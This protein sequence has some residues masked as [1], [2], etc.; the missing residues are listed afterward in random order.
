MA[1][2]S[3]LGVTAPKSMK[4]EEALRFL[5]KLANT[6]IDEQKKVPADPGG[7]LTTL[8]LLRRYLDVTG[9]GE[10]KAALDKA[11][12][13][14]DDLKKLITDV[15]KLLDAAVD[16]RLCDTEF[17]L[18]RP[19]KVRLAFDEGELVSQRD[20]D[21]RESIIDIAIED[22][23]DTKVKELRFGHC[24]RQGCGRLFYKVKLNQSYCDHQCANKAASARRAKGSDEST[25]R[26]ENAPRKHKGSKS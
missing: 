2:K 12:S 16:G 25:P 26:A 15:K 8:Y 18:T 17:T 9:E 4:I 22:L 5:V 20:G 19:R 3:E 24:Q 11:A 23:A 7:L 14:P 1:R 13:R 10:L 21:L 6:D